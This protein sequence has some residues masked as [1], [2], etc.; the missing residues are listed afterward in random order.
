LPLAALLFHVLKCRSSY[1]YL[2]LYAR[3]SLREYFQRKSIDGT[4]ICSTPLPGSTQNRPTRE[5]MNQAATQFCSLLELQNTTFVPAIDA[6]S[7]SPSLL[8]L[9]LGASHNVPHG[10]EKTAAQFAINLPNNKT[11]EKPCPIG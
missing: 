11:F 2:L 6:F 1:S 10:I 5:D 9:F 7:P 8:S 3:L 4:S